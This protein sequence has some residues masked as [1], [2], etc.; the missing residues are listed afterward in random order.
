MLTDY[1]WPVGDY[2]LGDPQQVMFPIFFLN[3]SE[4]DGRTTRRR[5]VA[6]NEQAQLG[7]GVSTR[8]VV[9]HTHSPHHTNQ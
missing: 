9:R 8:W 3:P 5:A 1:P 7:H 4:T 6:D 2:H